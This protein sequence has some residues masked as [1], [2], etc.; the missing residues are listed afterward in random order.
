[1]SDS[2][3]A[4]FIVILLLISSAMVVS[5][6]DSD[7]DGD[8]VMNDVDLCPDTDTG[9]TVDADGCADNQRDSDGDGF[10]DGSD[11]CPTE[12]GGSTEDRSGCPDSDEDGW[13]DQGDSFPD[14]PTQWSDID[15]DGYGDNP[16]GFLPDAFPNDPTE[17]EDSDGDGYGDNS[18]GCPT[19]S[20]ESNGCPDR[21]GDGTPDP[22]DSYPDDPTQWSDIDGDGFGDNLAGNWGDICPDVFALSFSLSMRGCPDSDGDGYADAT[23]NFSIEDGADS[24]PMDPN[25]WGL[26]DDMDGVLIDADVCPYTQYPNLADTNGCDPFQLDSDADGV[27]DYHDF[28]PNSSLQ[29]LVD[30]NGCSSA[31]RDSD[32]DGIPDSYDCYPDDPRFWACDADGD[33]FSESAD[34][35]Q[36]DAC[37]YVPGNSTIDVFG[38]PDVDGDGIS[39]IDKLLWGADSLDVPNDGFSGNHLTHS[40]E[41]DMS[42]ESV[43]RCANTQDIRVCIK[44]VIEIKGDVEGD[45]T[46]DMQINDNLDGTSDISVNSD[47]DITD[48]KL[49]IKPK[50]LISF[51]SD[52]HGVDH[53]FDL[54]FPTPNRIYPGQTYSSALGLYYWDDYLVLDD[55]F[56]Y[57]D[58]SNRIE[59]ESVDLAPIITDAFE[60]AASTSGIG[61]VVSTILDQSFNLR[62]PFSIGFYVD[63]TSDYNTVS[64]GVLD[65]A[66]HSPFA[67]R[68]ID[69]CTISV[70]DSD[71]DGVDESIDMCTNT[72]AGADVNTDGCAA[73]EIDPTCIDSCTATVNNNNTT[74][75]LSL[76]TFAEGTVTVDIG[77]Y[78]SIGIEIDLWNIWEWD[79]D[80]NAYTKYIEPEQISFL[81]GST[82]ATFD[83]LSNTYTFAVNGCTDSDALNQNVNAVYN[84]SSCTYPE[85]EPMPDTDSDSNSQ[86]EPM[87]DT[88]SD[89]NSQTGS[90]GASQSSS[91]II[92]YAGA[93]IGV[94]VFAILVVFLFSRR[95]AS[96]PDQEMIG[97]GNESPGIVP[98]YA[99]LTLQSNPDS[100]IQGKF[101]EDGYEWIEYP[102][103]QGEWYWRDQSTGEWML[104]E[105]QLPVLR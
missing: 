63:T 85:P 6:E 60:D 16:E 93:G 10:D 58:E 42:K 64:I 44:F 65:G 51:R 49:K 83:G 90:S 48:S 20:G 94:L 43:K 68:C 95:S 23:S 98:S 50:L 52:T 25:Q 53:D 38:C 4:I 89:S 78:L 102:P 54:Y 86:P 26:D 66:S 79:W 12:F 21:D 9:A 32:G 104:H 105:D 31:E 99:P 69:G 91:S 88:D 47:F 72:P 7:D 37:P 80:R 2:S 8:G 30:V 1:M 24:S 82:S 34:A 55:T 22:Q 76:Y 71:G 18:D 35:E 13:S 45:T 28:C 41:F 14:D 74:S 11:D 97:L 3:R 57:D 101:A 81:K 103:G 87:P 15:G 70:E 19:T 59:L 5:A 84:D 33:G 77:G 67:Q 92:L 36:R 62:I 56:N 75:S 73:S 29:D 27:I 61:K 96:Q 46:L 100:N 40:Q 39:D 17:W